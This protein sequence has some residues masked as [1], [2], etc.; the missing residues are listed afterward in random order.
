MQ[1]QRLLILI[2]C[3]AKGY[4]KMSLIYRGPY[5]VDQ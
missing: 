5:Q 4:A 3:R 2:L 1:E